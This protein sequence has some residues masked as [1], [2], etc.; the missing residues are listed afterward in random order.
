MKKSPYTIRSYKSSDLEALN[1]LYKEEER[2]DSPAN[3][4]N[5]PGVS[6]E[7]DLF[8]I[9]H[10]NQV[11][12]YSQI[13]P[14]L[15]IDR[16]ILHCWVQPGHRGNGLGKEFLTRAINRAEELSVKV[17]HVY[18]SPDNTKAR[19]GLPKLG[20]KYV[21]R[22]LELILDIDKV[23]EA[24]LR[25]AAT[26]CRKLQPG[27]EEKIVDIQNR[28]FAEHWGYNPN[29]AE[30][31]TYDINIGNRSP[32]DVLLVC[33]EDTITGYCWTEILTTDAGKDGEK[34]GTIN[35]I[36]TEPDYRGKGLGKKVLLAGLAYLKE[37]GVKT[38]GLSVDSE[39]RVAYELYRS[40]GFTQQGST[41]W[42]EKK[43]A[44]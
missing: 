28:A 35:M 11:I 18:L 6:P 44:D 23:S 31:I 7:Q 27:E 19:N 9:E 13:E 8:V 10:D 16:V 24:V 25:E 22:Y 29:T 17:V 30:T 34:R 14:E 4:L 5:R 32:D 43:L 12:G 42:Y 39:N 2:N 40:I 38:V 41:L 3:R 1:R 26:G 20:F 21:R 33:E 36:G 37:N 15:G